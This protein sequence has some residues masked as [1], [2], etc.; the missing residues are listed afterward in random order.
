M[1]RPWTSK[2]GSAT[3]FNIFVDNFVSKSVNPIVADS[4]AADR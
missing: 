4:E 3:V 1:R 2:R